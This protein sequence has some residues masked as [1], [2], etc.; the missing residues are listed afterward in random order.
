MDLWA[1]IG[2]ASRFAEYV[3]H[4]SEVIGHVDRHRPLALYCTGLLLP[5]ERKSVEPMAAR[6]VPDEVGATG[7]GITS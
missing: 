6:I 4:L 1:T 2:V 7:R 3:E 5:G